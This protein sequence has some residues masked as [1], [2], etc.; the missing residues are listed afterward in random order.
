MGRLPRRSYASAHHLARRDGYRGGGQAGRQPLVN[1]DAARPDGR[2]RPERLA[3]ETAHAEL[4]AWCRET[5]AWQV[6]ID[7][8]YRQA[9]EL[10]QG[11]QRVAPNGSSA[12]IQASAQEGRAWARLGDTRETYA[13]LRRVEALVSP[14]PVP[15]APE[16]HYQ[17][18]PAK[19]QAYIATTL[20][21]AGDPAAEGYARQVLARIES[22]ADGSTP[23]RERPAGATWPG[24]LA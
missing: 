2:A 16:H 15:D 8:D 13:A 4:G 3:R 20:S 9:A 21:W 5:R 23:M 6:L 1:G 24:A 18:D 14:R 22:A 19:Q 11:A 7:G 10:S 17:Y 12:H